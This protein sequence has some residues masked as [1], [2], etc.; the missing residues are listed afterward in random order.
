MA[1]NIADIKE[2]FDDFENLKDLEKISLSVLIE[3]LNQPFHFQTE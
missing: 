1:Q 2:V 3:Y